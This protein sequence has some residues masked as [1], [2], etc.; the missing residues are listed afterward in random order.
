MT[1]LESQWE[2]FRGNKC[3]IRIF[4]ILVNGSS[5]LCW[6]VVSLA[7]SINVFTAA[8]S[9]T[10][11]LTQAAEFESGLNKKVSNKLNWNITFL[12]FSCSYPASDPLF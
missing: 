9:Y 6:L 4:I 11:V 7:A 5:V 10:L 1:S 8:K 3:D 2:C 12:N